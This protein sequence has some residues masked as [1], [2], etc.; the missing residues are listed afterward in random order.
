MKAYKLQKVRAYLKRYGVKKLLYKVMERRSISSDYNEIRKKELVTEEILE[1]QRNQ[2]FEN[3][4]VISIIMPA[5]NT[6]PKSF[7]ETLLS[8]KEQSYSKWELCVSDGGDIPVKPV[9]D[10]IFG[11]D[12]RIKYKKLN[13]NFGI[14]G[15][16]NKA[17][18]LATGDFVAFLD[19]D[20]ILEPDV[21][22]EVTSAIV[23]KGADMVYTDEDKVSE[24][25][26]NYFR[27]YRKP[28]YNRELLLSNNYI[29]HFCA[30]SRSIIAKTGG[31]RSEYDGAQDYD[32]F[33]RCIEYATRIEH[34]NK[35]LYHWRVS[36][37]STSDNPFNKEYTF[38]AGK[39]AIEDY[40]RRN[41][42]GEYTEVVELEDPG[43]FRVEYKG[44]IKA[45]VQ[46]LKPQDKIIEADYY[47]LIDDSMEMLSDWKKHLVG[48]AL[49]TDA[50]IVGPKIIKNRKYEY[51]GLAKRG[52]KTTQSLKGCPMWYKGEFNLGITN[53]NV[54]QA[55]KSGILVSKS[56]VKRIFEY[57][58]KII[59]N[60]DES[61]KGIKMV[62]APAA[63]LKIKK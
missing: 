63:L 27:P 26:D 59:D 41:G 40:L 1:R 54:S 32:L 49:L 37:Q 33:L 20:D 9:I 42:L 21:L 47:L 30:I 53:M 55:P 39:R 4:P 35:I 57:K 12:D 62:Y 25:L 46:V 61:F 48:T 44:K 8:V 58:G 16:S 52:D 43:Y 11:N 5:Y 28:D 2:V 6:P 13:E 31:F 23:T 14:S 34:V 45:S 19:H 56:I 22:Y 29:C 18:E 7:K 51:N 3:A 15:N 60:S 10:E 38:L 36:T 24:N 50:D 17:L